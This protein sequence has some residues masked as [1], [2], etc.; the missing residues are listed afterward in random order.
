MEYI[1]TAG[2]PVWLL[3]AGDD[4]CGGRYQMSGICPS[5]T[6]PPTPKSFSDIPRSQGSWYPQLSSE[7]Q[8]VTGTRT[9]K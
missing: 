7:H 2:D 3:S 9:K 6:R 1:S 5:D 8:T 4:G